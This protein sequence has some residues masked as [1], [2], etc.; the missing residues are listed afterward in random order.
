MASHEYDVSVVPAP[1]TAVYCETK[2]PTGYAFIEP[3][4]ASIDV[5]WDRV[6]TRTLTHEPLP[7]L[8]LL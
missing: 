7:K 8:P 2:A 4:C 5:T 1:S 6:Y 3:R